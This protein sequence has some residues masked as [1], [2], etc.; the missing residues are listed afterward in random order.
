MAF[1]YLSMVESYFFILTKT[2]IN[3]VY[4]EKALRSLPHKN[5]PFMQLKMR[6]IK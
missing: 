2:P 1:L 5:D 6:I 4:N 3:I